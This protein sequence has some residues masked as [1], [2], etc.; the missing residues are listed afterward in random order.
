[1]GCREKVQIYD[2]ETGSKTWSGLF[3]VYVGRWGPWLTLSLLHSTLVHETTVQFVL[4]VCFSPDGKLLA[5]GAE[6][7]VVRVSSGTFILAIVIT[8]TIIFDV[9]AQHRT[10]SGALDLGHRQEANLQ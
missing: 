8:V 10:T 6:D 2:T 9:N 7:G 4:S 3:L 1:M 5:T